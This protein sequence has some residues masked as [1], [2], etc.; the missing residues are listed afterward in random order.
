MR[1]FLSFPP[2]SSLD[3]VK[4][5]ETSLCKKHLKKVKHR[6]ETYDFILMFCPVISRVKTDIMSAMSALEAE[7]LPGGKPVVLVVLHHTFDPDLCVPDSSRIVDRNDVIV[8]VDC[9]FYETKGLLKC[10]RNKMA[11]TKIRKTVKSK[12]GVQKLQI[13]IFRKKSRSDEKVKREREPR[14]SNEGI[15]TTEERPTDRAKAKKMK[16]F[17][18]FPPDS[19]LDAVKKIETSLC[20]KHLK[21]VKHREETYD[22][23]LMFCPVISRVKTDIMSAMSA[24]EAEGLPG[25]KPVVLVVL[26][27]TFNP[28]LCVPDSSRIVDRNDVILAVDCLFYETKG[29]LKC[30]RNNMALKKIR[31]TVKLKD[32]RR[33]KFWK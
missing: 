14:V 30:P 16:R 11:L 28:D 7:G 13:K 15:V 2:D 9:L 33:S 25:G 4:K 5:I 31:K 1:K 27:H 32:G 23:I 12:D 10:P 22:F 8:A 20:K 3:A 21:K 26:H 24:L 6:G 29:L 17:L 19:S 18:S